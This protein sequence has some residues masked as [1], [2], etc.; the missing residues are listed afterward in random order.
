[1]RYE[2]DNENYIVNV[3]FGCYGTE[4]KEYTGEIPEGYETLPLWAENANIRAYKLEDGNLIYDENRDRELQ[5]KYELET[6]QNKC[7][8]QKY[9]NDRLIQ[10]NKIYEDDLAVIVAGTSLVELTDTK[11][12][13]LA[14]ITLTPNERI[15]NRLMINITNGNMLE[16]KA[17]SQT[18]DGITFKVNE[19]RTISI[20]GTATKNIELII[21]GSLENTSELFF[22]KKETNYRQCGLT[23]DVSLKL[24]N[25]D[26]T[27]RTLIYSGSNETINLSETSYVTCVTLSI[28][29]GK[30]FEDVKITPMLTIGEEDKE[31][32][33]YKGNKLEIINL[34]EKIF[35]DR[36]YIE[37]EYGVSTFHKFNTLY[38][39]KTLVPS[40][41]LV[42]RGYT[43]EVIYEMCNELITLDE[44]TLIQCDKDINM[45]ITYFPKDYI[46]QQ[47]AEIKIE[48]DGINLEVSKKVGN[49]E[50]ISK[51][52]QSAEAITIDANRININGT[53]SANGGF[54]INKDGSMEAVNGTFTGGKISLEGGTEE[55]PNLEIGT[56]TDD[57]F[58]KTILTNYGFHSW[59]DDNDTIYSAS[60]ITANEN[61]AFLSTQTKKYNISGVA[62]NEDFL[63]RC[64]LSLEN[65]KAETEN[66]INL[67]I[68]DEATQI[69]LKKDNLLTLIQPDGIWTPVLTQTSKAEEKKNFEKL[70]NGLDIIKATDIYKYNLKHEDDTKKHI[71]FVI[72]DNYNYS[73]EITS[74]DNDGVDIYSMVSVCFKAIQEQQEQIEK[75]QTKLK[76]MEEKLN[77]KN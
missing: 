73:K 69:S 5:A 49:N 44:L 13:P 7:A 76:E 21:N 60:S 63:D 15:F 75:L 24:Y 62:Y 34:Y 30:T 64:F 29:K 68:S 41:S 17:V 72:G 2:I 19:D 37:L 16:N 67:Y 20:N 27:N 52:N 25:Y 46:G 32:I 77:E 58:D 42:P 50:I 40:K 57:L 39:S 51:I 26:G 53:V 48:Q 43:E 47:I 22:L 74:K 4:C 70:E 31:Y 28:A 54:K 66:E 23:S 8:T 12:A 10:N 35:Q 9:V 56:N 36:D 59:I 1:M 45:E 61:G 14:H 71:G 11:E 3:Y 55:N 6:E 38:P 18:I 33:Q 65:L